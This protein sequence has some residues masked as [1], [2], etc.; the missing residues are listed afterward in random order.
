VARGTR[1]GRLAL[2]GNM[3]FVV[4]R[5]SARR[6][7]DREWSGWRGDIRI[8]AVNIAC[9][10]RTTGGDVADTIETIRKMRI[11]PDARFP[12]VVVWTRPGEMTAKV[13]ETMRRLDDSVPRLTVVLVCDEGEGETD[14]DIEATHLLCNARGLRNLPLY[15]FHTPSSEVVMQQI[16]TFRQ[17]F[18]GALC[19][20]FPRSHELTSEPAWSEVFHGLLEAGYRFKAH[21]LELCGGISFVL[22]LCYGISLGPS[23]GEGLEPAATNAVLPPLEPLSPCCALGAIRYVLDH[24]ASYAESCCFCKTKQHPVEQIRPL[25]EEIEPLLVTED[26]DILF[27]DWQYIYDGFGAT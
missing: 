3:W 10:P 26:Q 7:G 27:E 25:C 13:L 19:E 11:G 2:H 6:G 9:G 12:P 14:R 23:L 16:G 15:V 8:D 20:W 24:P 18:G 22:R 4:G 21:W 1:E 5:G 17:M